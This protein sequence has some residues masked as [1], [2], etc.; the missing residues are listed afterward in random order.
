MYKTTWG[1]STETSLYVYHKHPEKSR[2]KN[3]VMYLLSQEKDFSMPKTM[4]P[5]L[6]KIN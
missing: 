6:A 5:D 3:A 1:H 2:Y 4:Q